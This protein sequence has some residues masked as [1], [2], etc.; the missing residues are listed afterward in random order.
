MKMKA[1]IGVI[2]PQVKKYQG[3]S[4]PLEARRDTEW[5]PRQNFQKEPIVLIP[6]FWFPNHKSFLF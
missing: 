2:C 4:A 5:V 6:D 3:F 1:D